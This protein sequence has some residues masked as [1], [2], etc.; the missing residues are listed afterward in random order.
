MRSVHVQNGWT[1]RCIEFSVTDVAPQKNLNIEIETLA[2]E[3]KEHQCRN[4]GRR[5][6]ALVEYKQR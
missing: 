5:S 1:V 4:D 6:E 2:I 3:K